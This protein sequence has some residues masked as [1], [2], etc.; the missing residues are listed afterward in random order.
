MR[1]LPFNCNYTGAPPLSHHSW[2]PPSPPR[3]PPLIQPSSSPSAL[4]SPEFPPFINMLSLS[5]TP[6]PRYSFSGEAWCFWPTIKSGADPGRRALERSYPEQRGVSSIPVFFPFIFPSLIATQFFFFCFFLYSAT[7]CQ[8]Y[9][10]FHTALE[11][12]ELLGLWEVTGC[13]AVDGGRSGGARTETA[14]IFRAGPHAQ[15]I[16]GSTEE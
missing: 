8:Q 12:R 13:P 3:V 7:C 10:S 16:S 11:N 9:S 14:A 4:C 1:E 5:R 6:P 15:L 2:A